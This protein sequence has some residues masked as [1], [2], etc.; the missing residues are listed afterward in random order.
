MSF[1]KQFQMNK[2]ILNRD[3]VVRCIFIIYLFSL[4]VKYFNGGFIHQSANPILVY[5]TINITYWLFLLFKIPQFFTSNFYVGLFADLLLLF[6]CIS[7]IIWPKKYYLALM[8]TLG[9]WLNYMCY[10]LVNAY[11][12]SVY[13]P[14]IMSIPAIFKDATKFSLTFWAIR[15][16]ACFLYFE[17]GFLK[18]LRGGIFNLDQ[19]TN[20]IKLTISP[21]LV[22]NPSTGLNL[23]FK[24]FL[25]TN[26]NIAQLLF[27]S[28]TILELCF[29]IGFFTRKYDLLLLIL[30]LS[31]HIANQYILNIPFLQHQVLFACC[32][33]PWQKLSDYVISFNKKTIPAKQY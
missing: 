21:Y 20:S 7:I 32:F 27:I 26:P 25:I 6:S 29:L 4:I 24:Y 28:A 11:Q 10:C 15:F 19:M 12:P 1:K 8:F 22:Q 9:Y 14:L 31:F 30:F 16:W 2:Q 23:D 5:P 3:F 33:I 17:A 18:I 13:A